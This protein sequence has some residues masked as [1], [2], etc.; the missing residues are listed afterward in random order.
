MHREEDEGAIRDREPTLAAVVGGSLVFVRSKLAV[1]AAL[2]CWFAPRSARA[3][4][5]FEIQVYDGTANPPGV[6]GLEMH[7]N[8]WATGHRQ[9]TPP[10]APL[11]GQFHVTL[12]PSFG[13]L[14]WWEVGAYLQMA[15]RTDDGA[16]DWAGVKLRSK[17]V[18]P[19]G[20]FEHVRLGINLEISYVPEIYESAR[21]GSEIRPIAAY[22]DRGWLAVINPILDQALAGSGPGGASDGPWFEPAVKAARALG[23]IALGLEYYGSLGPIASPLPIAQQ[24]HYVYEVLD[25]IGLDRVEFNFGVGEGLTTASEG[26]VIKAILGYEFDS[27]ATP[28]PSAASYRSASPLLARGAAG[29]R[30]R[31]FP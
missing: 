8:E 25:L 11:H 7:L 27:G 21:W 9:A 29:S 13:V 22:F 19:P 6:A 23:P 16:F 5:A 17:F 26:V 28:S 10:E 20:Q 14:P 12:E 15:D 31:L 30:R 2:F 24:E 1:V 3:L 4:D 18:T